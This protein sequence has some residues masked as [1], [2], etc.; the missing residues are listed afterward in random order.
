MSKT[1]KYKKLSNKDFEQIVM[2]D[3]APSILVFGAEWSGNSEIMDSMMERVSK[4]FNADIH[5]Y[6][7]DVEEQVEISNYF[8]VHQIPTTI[9]IK[10]GEIIDLVRGFIPA[11]K[12][13]KKIN[14]I[15][16]TE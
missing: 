15:Y 5:F 9:M 2:A 6:K 4:E 8:N 7:V 13:R 11:S 14:D 3:Q 16:F 1:L 12:I 10:D